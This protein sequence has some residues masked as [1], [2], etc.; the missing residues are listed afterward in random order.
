MLAVRLP[1]VAPDKVVDVPEISVGEE[2]PISDAFCHFTTF[3][4]F[5][6]S[7]RSAGVVP[8]QIV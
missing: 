4:V 6:L 5:P 2:N 3:P 8:E 7:I 1:I